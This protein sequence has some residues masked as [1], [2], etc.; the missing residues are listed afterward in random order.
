MNA[1]WAADQTCFDSTLK[2]AKTASQPPRCKAINMIPICTAAA[3]I[4][5]DGAAFV[6]KALRFDVGGMSPFGGLVITQAGCLAASLDSRMPQARSRM[7]VRAQN[8]RLA[9][10]CL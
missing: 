2:P 8:T 3:S 5:S 7:E 10:L 4:S 9:A 6:Q 1:M